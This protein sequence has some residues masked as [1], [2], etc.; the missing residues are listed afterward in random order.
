MF[1]FLLTNGNSYG[2]MVPKTYVDALFACYFTGQQ[3]EI[4]WQT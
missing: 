4:S 1:S 3:Y 2:A